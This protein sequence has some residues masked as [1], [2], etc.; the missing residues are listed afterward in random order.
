MFFLKK[1]IKAILY[2]CRLKSQNDILMAGQV[3]TQSSYCIHEL[4]ME[5][6]KSAWRI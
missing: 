2:F 3:L 5:T 1:T 4:D 6:C